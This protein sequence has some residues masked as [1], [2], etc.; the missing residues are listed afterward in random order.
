MTWCAI[1]YLNTTL[2]GEGVP[3]DREIP[4]HYKYGYKKRQEKLHLK[5]YNIR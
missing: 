3:N 5:Y 2:R 4:L 1:R